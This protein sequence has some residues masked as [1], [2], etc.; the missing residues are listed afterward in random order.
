MWRDLRK[1]FFRKSKLITGTLVL[2]LGI[3]GMFT[4]YQFFCKEA[5]QLQWGPL[6]RMEEDWYYYRSHE[7]QSETDAVQ[8]YIEENLETLP[9]R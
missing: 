2:V 1:C 3:V 5:S 6:M 7:P 9:M 8:A 4:Q